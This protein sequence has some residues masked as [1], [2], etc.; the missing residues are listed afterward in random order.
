MKKAKIFLKA[1]FLSGGML[2]M[3]IKRIPQK[4]IID[5]IRV[6]IASHESV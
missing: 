1:G 2:K 6:F 3:K 4:F 5:E